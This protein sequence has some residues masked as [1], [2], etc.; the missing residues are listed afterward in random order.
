[1]THLEPT[2]LRYVYDKL[3]KGALHAENAAALPHGFI[4]LYEK[5]F[6][7]HLTADTRQ[8]ILRRLALWALFKGA[9]SAQL[10]AE[11]LNETEEATKDLVDTYSKWFNSPEPGMYVLYHERLRMYLLQKLKEQEVKELHEQ[12]ITYLEKAIEAQKGGDAEH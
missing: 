7:E 12:L 6:E 1:M 4:G 11:V 2:Y 10:A 8:Q 3:V 9:V 5:L